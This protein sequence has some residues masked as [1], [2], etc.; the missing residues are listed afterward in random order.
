MNVPYV[1][2]SE[3]SEY[4][5]GLTYSPGDVS[6]KGTIVLDFI[7]NT[8]SYHYG[9]HKR[10]YTKLFNFT[11]NDIFITEI[12]DFIDNPRKSLLP[13]IDFS[14][15]TLKIFDAINNQSRKNKWIKI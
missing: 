8:Y 15:E 14:S 3:I 2:L 1:K 6:K 4:F 9:G 10:T 12:K 11:R 7:K 13:D 5:N